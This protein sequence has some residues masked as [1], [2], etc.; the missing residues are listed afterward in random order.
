M[1]RRRFHSLLSHVLQH[2]TMPPESPMGEQQAW[3]QKLGCIPSFYNLP[4]RKCALL[5]LKAIVTHWNKQATHLDDLSL[6]PF[7]EF[8]IHL[9]QYFCL[10]LDCL[11]A[12]IDLTCGDN[13]SI[14]CPSGSITLMVVAC[15][16]GKEI[17][18]FDR[19]LIGDLVDLSFGIITTKVCIE[20]ARGTKRLN[21][22]A[23]R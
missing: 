15:V 16:P 10:C 18:V 17:D 12:S 8:C 13:T 3:H 21:A 4:R 20:N 5:G 2:L 9:F 23:R 14:A 7:S 6:D 1:H 11:S 22:W 19:C